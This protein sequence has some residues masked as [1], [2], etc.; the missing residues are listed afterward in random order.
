MTTPCMGGWCT[1]RDHCAH[2]HATDRTNP[3]ER[4]CPPG[5]D[6]AGLSHLDDHS[7][8]MADRACQP[9]AGPF[10]GMHTDAGPT[11]S[12]TGQ[13][14]G[15]LTNLPSR[16]SRAPK[17]PKAQRL[18]QIA[19]LL[20]TD[21]ARYKDIQSA[22]GLSPQ[23][24]SILLSGLVKAGRA[25]MARAN[26]DGDRV[27][28]EQFYFPDAPSCDT[29]A[30]AWRETATRR[31]REREQIGQA[32]RREQSRLAQAPAAEARAKAAAI[33]AGEKAQAD[34]RRRLERE[35]AEAEKQLSLIHI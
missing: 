25:F 35:A 20:T 11:G 26:P 5:Q 10:T 4:L 30:A 8:P 24:L 27:G 33:K 7:Y 1:R 17:M 18:D 13:A 31:R 21:G 28:F 2:Y 12:N 6:G 3:A 23:R 32:R 16:S 14:G 34:L 19:A 9:S 29:F 22:T 15:P